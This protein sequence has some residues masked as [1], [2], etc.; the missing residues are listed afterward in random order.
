MRKVNTIRASRNF[1]SDE[2][3][4]AISLVKHS[5]IDYVEYNIKKFEQACCAD[6]PTTKA[7]SIFAFEGVFRGLEGIKEYISLRRNVSVEAESEREYW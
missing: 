1:D 3:V 2:S 7:P 5:T 6:V 4:H